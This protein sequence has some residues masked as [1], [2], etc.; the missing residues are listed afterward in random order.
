[1]K[2]KGLAAGCAALLLAVS[3]T[4]GCSPGGACVITDAQGE[5]LATVTDLTYGETACTRE[6]YRAYVDL[7]I[8]E[9]R[10]ALEDE[11]LLHGG[12][13][14][15]TAFSADALAAMQAACEGGGLETGAGCVVTDLD[16]QILAAYS[17]G[18]DPQTNYALRSTYPCS[19]LKPLSVYAPALDKGRINWTTA[20]EDSPVKTLTADDGA[21]TPWPANAD[22]QYTGQPMRVCDAI[23]QSIN[24]VAVRCLQTLTVEES[25]AFLGDTLGMNLTFEKQMIEQAGGEE[26]WGNL[27]LGYL[28]HGLSPVDMAGYYQIFAAGGVYTPPHAILDIR[29]SSGAVL[30]ESRAE[31]RQVIGTDTAC[32]MNHLLQLVTAPGGTGAEARLDGV[33]VAGKTGTSSYNQDNWFVGVTPDYS[34]A[35][36]HGEP[37]RSSGEGNRASRLFHDIL[38]AMSQDIQQDFPDDAGVRQAAYCRETGLLLSAECKQMEVGFFR[39][40]AMPGTCPGHA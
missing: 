21:E 29:D 22:G 2:R 11:E 12:Y 3:G 6:E 36:W 7:V 4:S 5:R 17:T 30:F 8:Q 38:S 28:Y 1:M 20:F 23:R 31:P 24:T 26:I 9:A 10:Q 40:D 18:G 34:C 15:R 35:V 37:P 33:P 13:T 32:I 16:G 27:A 19:A 39:A 25:I 14:I